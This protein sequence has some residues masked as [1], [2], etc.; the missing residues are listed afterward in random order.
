MVYLGRLRFALLLV[1]LV[2]AAPAAFAKAPPDKVVVT[3]PRLRAPLEITD[4]A[5]LGQFDPWTGD[6][7]APGQD[8]LESLPTPDR[9][10][11]LLIYLKDDGGIERVIYA[12]SYYADPATGQGYLRLPGVGERWNDVNRSTIL[13]DG[14][15]RWLRVSPAFDAVMQ[16]LLGMQATSGAATVT[17]VT[18]PGWVAWV[19]LAVSLGLATLAGGYLALR[20]T[21]RLSR[22]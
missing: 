1:A 18:V 17:G 19:L 8:V 4:L 11:D 10:Y 13:R 20:S 7:F 12:M 16:R 22:R 5:T 15:A 3:G 21:R 2:V 6:F 9:A 14:E